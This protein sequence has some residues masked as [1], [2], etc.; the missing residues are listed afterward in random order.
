MIVMRHARET[1]WRRLR[2]ESLVDALL[3]RLDNVDIHLVEAARG[4]G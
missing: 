3:E 4:R 2:G 1:G